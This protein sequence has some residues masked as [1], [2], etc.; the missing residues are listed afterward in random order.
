MLLQQRGSAILQI[1]LGKNII[2][3]GETTVCTI[4]IDNRLSKGI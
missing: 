2:A 3:L 4:D 1:S